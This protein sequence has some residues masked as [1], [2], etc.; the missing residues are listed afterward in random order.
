MHQLIAMQGRRRADQTGIHVG[1]FQR[2]MT[3][4]AVRDSRCDWPRQLSKSVQACPSLPESYQ[5]CIYSL[6]QRPI[7]CCQ[8]LQAA[9]GVLHQFLI[10]SV[11]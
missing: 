8:S 10:T 6:K 2:N 9:L 4:P 1:A 11:R 7:S 5:N 3:V